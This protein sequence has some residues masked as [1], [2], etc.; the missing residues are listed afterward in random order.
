[1]NRA[2]LVRAGVLFAA[3]QLA[4]Y[5]FFH[6]G[7]L[8]E[9]DQGRELEARLKQDYAVAKNRSLNLPLYRT[10]FGDIDRRLGE[11]VLE[12]PGQ[13]TDPGFDAVRRTALSH[14]LRI[15]LLQPDI[16]EDFRDS[17]ASIG[18]RLELAGP[19]HRVGAFIADLAALPGRPTLGP[20]AIERSPATGLVSLKGEVRAFRYVDNAEQAARQKAAAAAQGAK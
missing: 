15:E 18:A 14:G 8:A 11:A 4:A 7:Q 3:T 12:L 13:W 6:A 16:A 10:Q 19:F 5:G 20:F 17:H 9:I 1:M 2:A